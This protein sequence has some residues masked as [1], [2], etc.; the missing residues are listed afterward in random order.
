MFTWEPLGQA[1]ETY[2]LDSLYYLN[3][4]EDNTDRQGITTEETSDDDGSSIFSWA[5]HEHRSWLIT[6]SDTDISS[7]PLIPLLQLAS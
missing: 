3:D 4:E 2:S 6:M 1:V 5:A 7:D